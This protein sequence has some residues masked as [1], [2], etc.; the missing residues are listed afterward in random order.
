ME[1][2]TGLARLLIVYYSKSGN[3]KA[4]AEAISQGAKDY[5]QVDVILKDVKDANN[6][7][8]LEADS[9]II[10]SPTY[11]RMPAWPLKKFIDESIEIYEKLVRKKGAVFSSAG[12]EE[13]GA[14]CI[15]AMENMLKEH[16]IEIIANGLLI[17]ED[18]TD[19]EIEQ[20]KEFGSKIAEQ[21]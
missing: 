3:T 21:I 5:G 11:F 10:G 14:F 12:D 16:G 7:D 1:E 15:E 4:M 2:K 6:N 8:L 17:E 9:I 13:S 19:E 20:C 18:P